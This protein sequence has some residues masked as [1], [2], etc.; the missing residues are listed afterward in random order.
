M[1]KRIKF[2]FASIILNARLDAGLTQSQVAEAVSISIR[3]YQRI[4]TGT[5]MPGSSTMLKLI[6][7]FNIDPNELREEVGLVVPV[8]TN[9]RAIIKR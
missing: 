5:T 2:K 3:W 9:T 7:F 4:E 6:I 1:K 8:S